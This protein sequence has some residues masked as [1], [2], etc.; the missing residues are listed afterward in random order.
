MSPS[1]AR[2]GLDSP[3]RLFDVDLAGYSFH[4]EFS[5]GN[6]VRVIA[7]SK[8]LAGGIL[9]FDRQGSKFD[10]QHTGEIISIQILDMDGDGRDEMITEEVGNRSTSNFSTSFAVYS[11]PDRKLLVLWRAKGFEEDV[12]P[13][14]RRVG[15]TAF[16]RVGFSEGAGV[17]APRLLYAMRDEV[18]GSWKYQ[19]WQLANGRFQLK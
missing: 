19:T 15:H 16:V 5:I 10:A 1:R 3:T 2:R 17:Y 11:V 8:N 4:R 6:G 18:T 9:V 12:A 13:P 14:S 7:I